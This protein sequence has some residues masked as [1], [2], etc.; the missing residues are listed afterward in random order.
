MVSFYD[1]AFLKVKHSPLLIVLL[2]AFGCHNNA[3]IRTQ[4]ILEKGEQ[5]TSLSATIPVYDEPEIYH[6]HNY[7]NNLLLDGYGF[8]SPRI[9]YTKVYGDSR[10]EKGFHIGLGLGEKINDKRLYL[11][12]KT[13]VGLLLGAQK[14]K[15]VRNFYKTNSLKIGSVAEINVFSG[16]QLGIHLLPSVT[17]TTQRKKPF[18][19]G[20][21]SVFSIAKNLNAYAVY[22]STDSLGSTTDKPWKNHFE[23]FKYTLTSVGIGLTA[24]Y[25][26]IKN[27]SQSLL[28]QIDA[29]MTHNNLY[30]NIN[31]QKEYNTLSYHYNSYQKKFFP[32][33]KRSNRNIFPVFSGSVSWV[34]F[35]PPPQ[36]D[37][38]IS[39]L[40]SLQKNIF[41]PKTGER[42]KKTTVVFDPETGETITYSNETSYFKGSKFTEKQLVGLAR[43]KAQEKHIAALWSLLGLAGVPSSVFGSVFGSLILGDL[44]DGT[45]AFPGF[46]L[47]GAFGAILPSMLAK[48]S[49]RLAKVVY[50]LDIKTERQKTKYKETYKLEVGIL[51][52]KSTGIGTV[53]GCIAFTAFIML[54]IFGN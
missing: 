23:S 45:L 21:H 32:P 44:S 1:Y 10:T 24:G 27:S 7:S 26:L 47:G 18:Y 20:T 29:T 38:L 30:I 39:P 16:G 28:L 13:D 35:K 15:V 53:G 42:L 22:S 34:F 41:N 37:H 12:K 52:Q 51:R 2:L 4:K 8:A 5:A 19:I 33:W 54:V 3:H 31:P 6:L 49:S 17:T 11:N 25:E 48:G 46:L 9:E 14:K 50:P 36:N 40:P 43:R